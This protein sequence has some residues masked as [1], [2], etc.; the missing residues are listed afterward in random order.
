MAQPQQQQYHQQAGYGAG[1]NNQ[2]YQYGSYGPQSH[3]QQ[4]QQATPPPQQ[5]QQAA[6]PIK[7]GEETAGW[8]PSGYYGSYDNGG[9]GFNWW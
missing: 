8:D 6:T 4:P 2:Q 1:Y 9:G 7:P 3:Q 5:Q